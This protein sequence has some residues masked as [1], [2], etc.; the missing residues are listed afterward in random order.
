[1]GPPWGEGGKEGGLGR[2]GDR[3]RGGRDQG[4]RPE[5]SGTVDM[6]GGGQDT[7]SG[8]GPMLLGGQSSKEQ[9]RGLVALE[10]QEMGAAGDW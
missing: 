4:A 3:E 10:T 8:R 6:K 1:M 7:R 5:E 2:K 9:G